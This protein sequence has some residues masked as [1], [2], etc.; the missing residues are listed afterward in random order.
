[1]DDPND[2]AAAAA[3]AP[4]AS[5]RL[6]SNST[7]WSALLDLPYFD[8]VRCVPIDVM[9][10]LLLGLCKHFMAI[11][12]G[13]R[14]KTS[15]AAV[16]VPPPD[17]AAAAAAAAVPASPSRKRGHTE[18]QDGRPSKKPRA[19]AA[20]AAAASALPSPST[21]KTGSEEG[22][23]TKADLKALQDSVGACT[24]PRDIG[25]M[26]SRLDSLD[27]VK[28]IEWLNLFAI[29]LVP[30]LR[31]RLT[32]SP[33]LRV[34]HV[35]M[36]QRV[37]SIVKLATS[38]YTTR[39][40]IAELHAE[41][42]QIMLDVE[43]L[44]PAKAAYISPNMHLSL[45]L[46]AQLR[47]HGPASSWWSM[48]YE[49]L[50]GM[51]ANIPFRPGNSS[52][53]T[54][55]RAL[56][57]LEVTAKA[58]PQLLEQQS[59]FG[60]F[61]IRLRGAPGFEH[62][63]RRTDNGGHYHWFRFVGAEGERAK[64]L[65]H[66]RRL[67]VSDYDVRGCEPYPGCLFNSGQLFR[68][69]S[70]RTIA[71]SAPSLAAVVKTPPHVCKKLAFVRRCLLAHHLTTRLHEVRAAYDAAIR[72]AADPETTLQLQAERG[73]FLQA[74]ALRTDVF[75]CL[76]DPRSGA[77]RTPPAGAAPAPYHTVLTWYQ[78]QCGAS[79]DRV[80]V[81][82]KLFYAGEEFGSDIVRGGQNAWSSASF[83]AQ[84]NETML[85]YGRVSYYVR[86]TFAGRAHDFAAFFWYDRAES[87]FS[88]PL[89]GRL[90][91]AERASLEKQ[92]QPT[93]L[94]YPIVTAQVLAD[95]IRDLVPVHRLTGR[96]IP[97]KAADDDACFMVCPIRS[98]VHG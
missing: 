66:L 89:H 21:A 46:A 49:R 98:R 91:R 85:W 32:L 5:A 58:T 48:P 59:V 56:A 19:H 83:A 68:A 42:V 72:A 92:V 31:S 2:G 74:S 90:S 40:M 70:T 4:D 33:Q 34:Q 45:H 38:Y 57:L 75:E 8:S 55:Q 73:Y 36:V 94:D 25:R 27:N 96:W 52:V 53:D 54:A 95:D 88:S 51:T 62:G 30:L 11:L 41:L 15:S 24:P 35:L 12:T 93:L 26:S 86:H 97:M 17:P 9:H 37:A 63:V 79:W 14:D 65:L 1:V 84:G 6:G 71:L 39:A 60:R 7:R 64:R 76:L 16:A 28:A 23:L 78:Q 13:H 87:S 80:D 50:M 43:Q 22:I 67:V 3:A 47:D 20:L 69:G 82:D 81:Y 18:Q 77:W 10:N 29:F 61:G 44:G